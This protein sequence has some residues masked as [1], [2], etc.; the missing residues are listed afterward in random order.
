M[1]VGPDDAVALQDGGGGAKFAVVGGGEAEASVDFVEEEDSSASLA[2]DGDGKPD[3]A[4]D[5]GGAEVE[6]EAFVDVEDEATANFEVVEE[7]AFAADEDAVVL[8]DPDGADEVADDAFELVVGF[9]E[10]V[11]GVVEDD[12]GAALEID[13]AGIGES[14]E[15]E[16]AGGGEDGVATT[17]GILAAGLVFCAEFLCFGNFLIDAG[18]LFLCFLRSEGLAV[19]SDD[20]MYRNAVDGE[21]FGIC[22]VGLFDVA[23][24][25]EVVELDA[26]VVGVVLA[27]GFGG[28]LVA[29][30]V[31]EKA[32]DG[33]KGLG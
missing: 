12:G 13:A 20:A 3:F 7:V 24:F 16:D 15:F 1:A 9:D 26:D 17:V 14:T 8:V 32:A 30:D 10:R 31:E 18:A 4:V 22:D 21:V 29:L 27:C 25:V 23:V 5:L 11:A 2:V 28:L 6:A 33:W 19:A